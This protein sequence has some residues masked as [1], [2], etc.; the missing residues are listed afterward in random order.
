MKN[1][2]RRIKWEKS[3]LANFGVFRD[4]I[5][6]EPRFR[7]APPFGVHWVRPW[8]EVSVEFGA[9]L[10]TIEQSYRKVLKKVERLL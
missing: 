1:G 5:H 7:I 3:G 6:M 9:Y 4:P 8:L 2:P 10:L